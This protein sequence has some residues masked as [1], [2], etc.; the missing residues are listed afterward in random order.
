MSMPIGP[1][2]DAR[3]PKP[4]LFDKMLDAGDVDGDGQL[5]V[6]EFETLL[7]ERFGENFDQERFDEQIGEISDG[8]GVVTKESFETFVANRPR[9]DRP[10]V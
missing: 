7:K 6:E 9:T 2:H 1:G 3:G 5:Q 8:N 4:P 10:S